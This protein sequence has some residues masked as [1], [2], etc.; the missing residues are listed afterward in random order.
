MAK[1]SAPR[2]TLAP[3]AIYR[4][5]L[6]MVMSIVHRITGGG[7]LFRHAADG[8]VADRR[9]RRSRTPTRASASFMAS[10]ARPVHPVRLHLGADPPHAGRHPPFDLGHR[11]RLRSRRSA[12]GW[13]MQRSIGSVV[14]DHHRLD[15][16]LS[17]HGRVTLMAGGK[18]QHPAR[19]RARPRLGAIG[20]RHFWRQRLT[21]VANVPLTIAFVVIVVALLG[22]NHAAVVQILGSPLV[23]DR[24]AAVHRLGLR[25]TC[26]SA[27]R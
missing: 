14:P 2:P 23:A 21:A 25:I 12:S 1:A 4:P 3:S 8:L 13:R 17:V 19:A 5:M 27:C 7:P 15:R 6:T 20:H 24:D 18:V 22:R 10:S 9:G 26:A 16:R 11:L